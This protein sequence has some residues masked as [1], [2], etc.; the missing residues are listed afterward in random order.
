MTEEGIRLSKMAD[1]LS[2]IW[3]GYACGDRTEAKAIKQCGIVLK[4]AGYVQLD[5]DQS[6]TIPNDKECP[7][8]GKVCCLHQDMEGNCKCRELPKE[9][10]KLQRIIPDWQ[11]TD[12]AETLYNFR[13]AMDIKGVKNTLW[14]LVKQ[15]DTRTIGYAQG[16]LQEGQ[17]G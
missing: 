11:L 7:K 5:D 6:L 8:Y 12:I 9:C 4:Q 10:R 14:Q 17:V 2:G 16:K 3:Y 15:Q 1:K 13:N